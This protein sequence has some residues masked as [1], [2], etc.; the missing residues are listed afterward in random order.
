MMD[1]ER[2]P[3]MEMGKIG[4][5]A[6]KD[7]EQ[8]FEASLRFQE[9]SGRCW[10]NAFNPALH[11]QAWQ[12]SFAAM[13]ESAAPTAEKQVKDALKLAVK[14]TETCNDFMGKMMSP[15]IGASRA[16]C[17]DYGNSMMEAVKANSEL[18]AEI[19][20]QAMN[21]FIEFNQRMAEAR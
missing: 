13:A 21:S 3:M 18:L 4:A 10:S 9:A 11:I 16:G 19:N 5:Q 7:W 15:E 12:K 1:S 8:A 20:A 2:N 14:N 6:M 17:A